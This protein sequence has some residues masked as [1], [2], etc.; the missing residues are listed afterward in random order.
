[1]NGALIKG[2]FE[3][4]AV[5]RAN[6]SVAMLT[7]HAVQTANNAKLER[8]DFLIEEMPQIAAENCLST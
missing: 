5:E 8:K 6:E 7:M 3:D 2:W 1:M 4:D